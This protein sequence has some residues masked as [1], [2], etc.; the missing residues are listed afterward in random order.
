MAL[1]PGIQRLRREWPGVRSAEGET[2]PPLGR[3]VGM[4]LQARVLEVEERIAGHDRQIAHVARQNEAAKRFMPGEGVGPMT[5]TAVVAP[6]GDAKAFSPGRQFAA[7]GGLVP[8]HCSTGGKPLLGRITK[9]GNVYLRT[10]LL[11]GARAVLQ[12]PPKRTAP[13]RCGGEAVRHRRG[14]N[15]AA[16]ALA[17]KPA[18]ILWARVA[19]GQRTLGWPPE[20][21]SL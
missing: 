3:S 8:K 12:C 6:G 21:P 14:D 1:A 11:H 7:W 20:G 5:A 16:V 2:L 18:R 19:R 17:A 9:R 10:L 15:I 13:K 4:E